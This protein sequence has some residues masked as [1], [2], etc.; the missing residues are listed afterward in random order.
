MTQRGVSHYDRMCDFHEEWS[1]LYTHKNILK[2]EAHKTKE[3]VW[4]FN[5][6]ET[7][8]IAMI[9]YK[10]LREA[11]CSITQDLPVKT[12]SDVLHKAFGMADDSLIERIVVAL[13]VLTLDASSHTTISLQAWIYMMSL[14]M[15]GTAEQKIKYCFTVY[16]VLGKGFI[17]RDQVVNLMRQFVYKHHEEEV[18]ETVKD[19]ADII[20]KKMDFDLDGIISFKDYKLSVD[21]NPML[22]EC[23]GQCLPDRKHVYAFLLTFTEKIKDSW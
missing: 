14:F 6:D 22:L 4:H 8:E 18:E 17:R 12:F 5:V 15:R 10:L 11:G 13:K 21:S 19:F 3:P 2:P 23:F 16:D 7:N 20:I 1:F 9:F